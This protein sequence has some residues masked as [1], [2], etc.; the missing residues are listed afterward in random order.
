MWRGR[1]AF[2]RDKIIQGVYFIGCGFRQLS[3]RGS[4]CLTNCTDRKKERND[5]IRKIQG[6]E[7]VVSI[8]S[9]SRC[10]RC[11]INSTL[12]SSGNR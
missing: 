5:M 3:D 8:Q 4:L 10:L 9:R 6:K 11:F 7:V 2:L 1:G 12:V